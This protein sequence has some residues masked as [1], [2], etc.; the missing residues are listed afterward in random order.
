MS[1]IPPEAWQALAQMGGAPL[2]IVLAMKWIW[3]GT[4]KRIAAI[5]ERVQEIH[6]TLVRVEARQEAQERE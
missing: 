6:D 5:E 1:D 2:V 4:G 3:N